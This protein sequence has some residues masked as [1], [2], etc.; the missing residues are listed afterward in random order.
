MMKVAVEGHRKDKLKHINLSEIIVGERFR[1]EFGDL[2]DLVESIR[3]KGIIQP[4]SVDTSFR[5]LAGG[6]RYAAATQLGLPT[7]PAVIREYVDEMD[8]REIELMENV[9]R[10]D[11]VWHERV[12]LTKAIDELHKKKDSNWSGR[13]TADLL[14]SSKSQVARDLQLADACEAIPEL[15]EY[16]TADDALKVLKKLE[17]QAIVQEL[18]GRQQASM[19][20]A[21]PK[22]VGSQ[23]ESGLKIMLKQAQANYMIGDVFEGMKGLK[24]NGQIQLIECD[25]PYGIDLNAQKASKDSVTSN[26]HTYEEIHADGYQAF[27]DQLTSELFRVAGKDCWLIFWY[28]PTWHQA[29]LDSLR[30]AGWLVDEIPAIWAKTQGQTLQPGLYFARGYEPFFLCRKG[31]PVMV[32]QGRLNV[33]NYSGVPGKSKYHPTQ[34]PTELIKDIFTTLAVGNAHVF[35]PF[36]GSGATLLSCYD[37]GFRGF[38]F[39]LNGEYKD[40]FMLEVEKQTRAN[41]DIPQE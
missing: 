18:R 41:F 17:E 30:R 27:L 14:D 38:G 15:R 5:L 25:P 26:V 24:S 28:G 16:K 37:L 32:E 35:V 34:R 20:K 1:V 10:K 33:F 11:F 40:R 6:R 22:V 31:K 4:I 19:D 12:A 21:D 2:D 23:L 39:D 9:Y 8:S 36:L 7:I 13:K 3:Q 29:V